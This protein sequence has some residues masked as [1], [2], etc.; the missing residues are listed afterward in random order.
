M[1]FTNWYSSGVPNLFLIVLA[2]FIDVLMLTILK[3][4]NKPS[5]LIEK[6]ITVRSSAAALFVLCFVF[7][8]DEKCSTLQFSRCEGNTQWEILL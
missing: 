8:S 3:K 2:Q 4:L 1:S 7:V 6:K 5:E